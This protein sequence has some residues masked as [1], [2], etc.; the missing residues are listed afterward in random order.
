MATVH[1]DGEGGL[2]HPLA[3]AIVRSAQ[4]EEGKRGVM[5]M[6]TV[7]DRPRDYPDGF[8]ARRFDIGKGVHGPT[9]HALKA[10]LASLRA[11][12]LEAGLTCLARHDDDEPQIVEV[13]L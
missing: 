8:I 2:A 6:W 12:F 10:D 9:E 7:Y 3:V 5:V 13:W 4:Y 11:I 1:Q